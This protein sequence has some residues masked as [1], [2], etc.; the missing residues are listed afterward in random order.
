MRSEE[1][2]KAYIKLL[3]EQIKDVE[4]MKG[5][6]LDYWLAHVGGVVKKRSDAAMDFLGLLSGTAGEKTKG[7]YDSATSVVEQAQLEDNHEMLQKG[8]DALKADPVFTNNESTLWTIT[9]SIAD[10]KNDRP[11]DAAKRLFDLN[12]IH[13]AIENWKEAEKN[14]ELNHQV[15]DE[16]D[17]MIDSQISKWQ[18]EL[19]KAK[20]EL[21]QIE[22]K[23]SNSFSTD[24]ISRQNFGLSEIMNEIRT[25][26][27]RLNS[28]IR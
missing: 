20:S 5:R 12:P 8:I 9:Q 22:S 24:G 6:D 27:D 13:S 3:N 18:D 10:L 7:F 28:N 14:Q 23:N 4:S 17:A 21:N 2:L 25:N 11:D 1:A 16:K 19:N 26:L 15:L